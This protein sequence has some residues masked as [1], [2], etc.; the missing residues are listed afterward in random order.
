MTNEEIVKKMDMTLADLDAGGI[1]NPEQSSTFIRKLLAT[2]TL[3]KQARAITMNA[4]QMKINK[5]GFADRIMRKANTT[6]ANPAVRAGR[7]LADA[8]RSGPTTEQIELNSKEVMAEIW[9][10]Y[11]V[12]ENNIEGGNINAS[13]PNAVAAPIQGGFKDT[14][15]ALIA[16]RAAIDLE[17]LAIRGDVALAGTDAYLGLLDGFLKKSGERFLVDAAGAPIN[18]ALFKNAMKMMPDQYLRNLPALRHYV[19]VDNDIEYKDSL[20]QRETIMGDNNL[21]G[22][23]KSYAYGVPLEPVSL[24]YNTDAIFSNP[25]NFIFGIQRQ[26]SIEVEKDI[27]ARAFIIVLTAKVDFQMEETMAAVRIKNIGAGE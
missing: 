14:I 2:P 16:E 7:Y 9:L 25:Q 1:L 4:S 12:I 15:M 20:A 11:D 26:I 3:L 8:D 5:I 13:G 21:Q 22:Y 23:S 6:W 17:E 24:M 18:K 19:S 27:R 10:P